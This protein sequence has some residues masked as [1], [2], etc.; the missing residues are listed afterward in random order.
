MAKTIVSNAWD[1]KR[2]SGEEENQTEQSVGDQALD[3]LKISIDCLEKEILG[4]TDRLYPILYPDPVEDKPVK[5]ES[6]KDV[7][8]TYFRHVSDEAERV[9]L[10]T[11]QVQE[12]RFRLG[13]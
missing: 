7:L 5:T 3:R 6:E 1:E 9:S 2:V 12:A 10:L 11:D 13:I 4:L 8:P